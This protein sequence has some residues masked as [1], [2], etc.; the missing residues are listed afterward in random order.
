M[1]F[2]I[3]YGFTGVFNP[4]KYRYS[5]HYKTEKEAVDDAKTQVTKLFMENCG[6]NG[7]PS[8]LDIQ[9]ES[10]ELKVPLK[11]LLDDYIWTG[12]GFMLFLLLLILFQVREYE[13]EHDNLCKIIRI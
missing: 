10:K 4:V 11:A 6:T 13:R 8:F 7:I 5:D 3:Y 12:L 1:Q 2:N 9:K